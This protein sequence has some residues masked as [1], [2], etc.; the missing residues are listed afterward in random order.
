MSDVP[1]KRRKLFSFFGLVPAALYVIWHLAAQAQSWLGEDHYTA[2]N[3]AWH[4]SPYYWPIVAALVFF[5]IAYHAA[6]GIFL[7]FRGRPNNARLPY[8]ANLKYLLQRLS[9]LGLLFF[10]PAHVYKTRIETSMQGGRVWDHMVAGFH[11]PLTVA[12]Y[13][14]S[15]LA[16]AF[17]VA[18]GFWLG[19]IT[20]GVTISRSAQRSWQAVSIVVFV[21]L[22]AMAAVAMAGFIRAPVTR[23]Y[24]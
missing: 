14:L 20:W 21:L 7:S 5:P 9:A 8:F 2:Q 12:I 18:N 15:M 24:F 23:G 17:H 10:I 11:E 22:S 6:Y 4:A 3:E 16:M 19:G 1:Y 13:G